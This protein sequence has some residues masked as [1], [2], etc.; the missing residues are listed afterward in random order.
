MTGLDRCGCGA[1]D[2]AGSSTCLSVRC[3][4]RLMASR[5]SALALCSEQRSPDRGSGSVAVVP[6]TVLR[7]R[8]RCKERSS[9]GSCSLT[10]AM[11]IL[12]RKTSFSPYLARQMS[13]SVIPMDL[14]SSTG[15]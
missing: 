6:H 10:M 13:D 5:A 1:T 15:L 8:R 11:E 7:L 12:S 3:L 9:M 4:A 14:S 2:T